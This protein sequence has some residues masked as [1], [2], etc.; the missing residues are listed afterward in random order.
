MSDV[1]TS[2]RA[3]VI[4]LSGALFSPEG[5]LLLLERALAPSPSPTRG[6]GRT[7]GESLWELPGGVADFGEP[8]EVALMRTFLENTDIEVVPDRPM[9]AWSELRKDDGRQLYIVH[10]DFVVR[11]TGALTGVD[12]NKESYRSFAWLPQKEALEHLGTPAMKSVGEH[13]F[14]MLSRTRRNS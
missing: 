14:A 9:G 13:A 7:D 12:I 2:N 4:Q 1:P 3:T 6:E 11:T 5:K 10:I 8:P